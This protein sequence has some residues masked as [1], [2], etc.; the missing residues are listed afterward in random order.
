MAIYIYG[1]YCPVAKTIRYVG[2]SARPRKRVLSHICGAIRGQYDHHAARWLRK[3]AKLGLRPKVVILH[4]IQPGEDWREIER[5]FIAS[6]PQ[7]GWNLTNT[8]AGGEGL[9]Y[10]NEEDRARYVE[11]CR[12]GHLRRSVEDRKASAAAALAAAQTPEARAKRRSSLL[13]HY[14]NPQNR[15]RQTETNR[16][17][18]SRS[19]FR[20]A[21]SE[22]S[23]SLWRR[24]EYRQT[25]EAQLASEEFRR[26][27][28]QRLKCRWED[29]AAREKMNDARW[30]P[31]KRREQAERIA[32][33]N[34]NPDPEMVKR[35]N[36]SIKAAW[37]RR[38]GI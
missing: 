12:A 7:R 29:P 38:K 20:E 5:A 18:W 23:K 15:Q 33:R 34:R 37:A 10:I 11:N 3:I 19:G 21:R 17:I 13:A 26:E 24:A 27:Q 28:A 9:D 14:S 16:E 22:V 1:L 8:T 4:E 32:A 35:R 30:T 25:R 2:K 31:K 36:A 6:G